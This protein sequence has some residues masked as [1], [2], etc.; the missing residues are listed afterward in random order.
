MDCNT[1][2]VIKTLFSQQHRM[3]KYREC[4]FSHDIISCENAFFKNTSLSCFTS[5]FGRS[6]WRALRWK[7]RSWASRLIISFWR[8]EAF[9]RPR[10]LWAWRWQ[11]TGNT[12]LCQHSC[13]RSWS[14]SQDA[15]GALYLSQY[16]WAKQSLFNFCHRYIISSW[17][18]TE[19]VPLTIYTKEES[20]IHY[21]YF[22]H[23]L[24]SFLC[25]SN[26]V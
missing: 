15:L 1:A 18:E 9:C 4:L 23:R 3:Q 10:C 6:T 8:T 2:V 13:A 25:S 14:L 24:Q 19:I 17:R 20:V 26:N 12:A 16:L 7:K 5:C 21:I 11:R 22:L